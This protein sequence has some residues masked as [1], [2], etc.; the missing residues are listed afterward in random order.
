[1]IGILEL[2]V[3]I[4]NL[5]NKKY[6]VTCLDFGIKHNILEILIIII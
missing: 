4:R 5:K 1:M 3:I 2:G 6:R